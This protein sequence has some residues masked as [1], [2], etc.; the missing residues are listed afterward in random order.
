M[1]RIRVQNLT[2]SDVNLRYQTEYRCCR[3][4][5]DSASPDVLFRLSVSVEKF[6]QSHDQTAFSSL[7]ALFSSRADPLRKETAGFRNRILSKQTVASVSGLNAEPFEKDFGRCRTIDYWPPD[8]N[9]AIEILAVYLEQLQHVVKPAD[10]LDRQ[11]L[12]GDLN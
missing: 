2:F 7:A 11:L 1:V 10:E 8:E 12:A 4:N 5:V 9:E 3:S 6:M